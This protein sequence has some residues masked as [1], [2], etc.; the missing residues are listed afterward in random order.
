MAKRRR[1]VRQE[2]SR[3]EQTM[4]RNERERARRLTIAVGVVLG[5]AAVVLAVGLLYQLVS[6]PNSNVATVNDTRISARDLDRQSRFVQ[7]QSIAQLEQLIQLQQSF[8][9]SDTSGFFASQIAQLQNDLID[10]E[11]LATKVLESMIDNVLVQQVAAERGV[12][13]TDAEIEARFESFIASQQGFVTAPDAT[14]TAEALAAA[15]ATPTMTPS[16]TPT[17]T[18]TTTATVT[19]TVVLPTPTVHIQTQEEFNTGLDQVLTNIASGADLSREEVRQIYR[20]SIVAQVLRERLTEQLGDEMPLAGEQV[21]A[22]HI[23]ISV[24]EDA[25]PEEDALALAKA[26][27]IT[28]RLRDGE[29]FATLA[30]EFSDDESNAASGGDLGFFGRGQMVEEFDAAA[31]SQEIDAIGDPVRTQFGYHIIQ[32]L[33]RSPGSPDFASWLEEQKA[34]ARIVRSLTSDR[35]PDLPPPPASLLTTQPTS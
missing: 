18:V 20:T 22:R 34:A 8:G 17:S 4:T 29:D 23:L 9:S 2:P 16:P 3:K 14:A 19:P 31:F 24:A 13:L 11:G 15:T 7:L 12:T 10:D 35:V 27:S 21:Q 30:Q 26:I 28:Q 32:V 33:D 1:Q 5:I 6:I 25:S